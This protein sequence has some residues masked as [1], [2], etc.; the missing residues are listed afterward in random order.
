MSNIKYRLYHD[1]AAERFR[2]DVSRMKNALVHEIN[3]MM[4]D[5]SGQTD[6]IKLLIKDKDGAYIQSPINITNV[7]EEIKEKAK[8]EIFNL[9]AL[10]TLLNENTL[11]YSYQEMNVPLKQ[12]DTRYEWESKLTYSR[13]TYNEC[14]L[15]LLGVNPTLSDLLHEDL[16]KIKK[17]SDL[18]DT[19]LR[20]LNLVCFRQH[21]N[22]RLRRRFPKMHINTKT[23]ILWAI[24]ERI[25]KQTLTSNTE[26]NSRPQTKNQQ[27]LVNI[28]ARK[29]ITD[30]NNAT[31][32][33]I[34]N[35]VSS[36]LEIKHNIRLKPDTIRREYLGKHPLY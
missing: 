26:N 14:L 36:E 35:C 5:L 3:T 31:R 25:L 13:L 10:E 6:H 21:E 12:R 11:N 8:R 16:Y 2:E 9:Q 28:I 22:N 29:I 23:F 18:F 17:E 34:S 19:K 15:I 30:D 7:S 24:E 27:Y 20:S 33:H 32:S 4:P 1:R